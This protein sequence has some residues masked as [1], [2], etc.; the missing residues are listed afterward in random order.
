MGVWA[1]KSTVTVR[2]SEFIGRYYMQWPLSWL[3]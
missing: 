2:G 1:A 3:L